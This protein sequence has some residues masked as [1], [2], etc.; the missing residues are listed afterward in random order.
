MLIHNSLQHFIALPSNLSFFTLLG[1]LLYLCQTQSHE[2]NLAGTSSGGSYAG[3]ILSVMCLWISPSRVLSSS[4][5]QAFFS[6]VFF[7]F[8]SPFSNSKPSDG[9]AKSCVASGCALVQHEWGKWSGVCT[10][11]RAGTGAS[12]NLSW[13]LDQLDLHPLNPFFWDSCK[14]LIS[15]LSAWIC[16]SY[17]ST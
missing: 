7:I 15:H 16:R 3:W 12:G 5:S 14:N 2:H 6:P 13:N 9:A 17:L 4:V 11:G 10:R 1:A 8:S